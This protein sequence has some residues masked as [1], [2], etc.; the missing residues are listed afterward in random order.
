[1][2][3]PRRLGVGK[4]G[5]S[6]RNALVV[7]QLIFQG[8]ETANQSVDTRTM[9]IAAPTINSSAWLNMSGFINSSLRIG[10]PPAR[11]CEH[12]PDNDIISRGAS[13]LRSGKFPT[14]GVEIS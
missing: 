8:R 6:A 1:M 9:N 13:G 12:F 5:P 7:E 14:S 2:G 4:S 3:H 10:K 11:C